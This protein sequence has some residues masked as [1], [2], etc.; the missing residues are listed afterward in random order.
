ML[1]A[2]RDSLSYYSSVASRFADIALYLPI[3]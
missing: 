2:E 1:A 3:P